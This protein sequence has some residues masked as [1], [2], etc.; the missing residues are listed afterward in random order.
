MLQR[1]TR[2]L[3]ASAPYATYWQQPLTLN[4]GFTGPLTPNL[5]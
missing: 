4:Q 5:R 3:E 1:R 2:Q